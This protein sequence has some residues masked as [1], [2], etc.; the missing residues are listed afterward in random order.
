MADFYQLYKLRVTFVSKLRPRLQQ[1]VNNL[2]N[3]LHPY[4]AT[5]KVA[6]PVS[7]GLGLRDYMNPNAVGVSSGT[8]PPPFLASAGDCSTAPSSSSSSSSNSGSTRS[9]AAHSTSSSSGALQDENHSRTPSQRGD[10][11]LLHGVH[12]K[13]SG[14]SG[15]KNANSEDPS[16]ACFQSQQPHQSDDTATPEVE[17]HQNLQNRSKLLCYRPRRLQRRAWR[18]TYL[19]APFRYK[20]SIRNYV[21]HDWR[22]EFSFYH[23]GKSEIRPVLSACLGSMPEDVNCKVE[24]VWAGGVAGTI[25]NAQMS[26]STTTRLTAATVD[27]QNAMDSKLALLDRAKENV[28]EKQRTQKERDHGWHSQ[29]QHWSQFGKF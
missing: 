1:C 20:T 10:E 14:S 5:S 22:Y 26:Y 17:D 6:A 2:S 23:V 27:A 7:S 8:L 13:N 16:S 18:I 15:A 11:A 4:Y 21:F 25:T 29:A 28:E 3:T 19:R 24:F 12:E 9:S